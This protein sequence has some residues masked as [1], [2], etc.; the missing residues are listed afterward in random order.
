MYCA[1]DIKEE[2]SCSQEPLKQ[3]T[4]QV[5]FSLTFTGESGS[6]LVNSP[7]IFP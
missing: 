7:V 4:N 5:S 1:G 2:R 6:Q 3:Q